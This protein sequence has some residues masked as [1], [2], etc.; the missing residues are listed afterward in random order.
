G[1]LLFARQV[2]D[3]G[4]HHLIFPD[5]SEGPFYIYSE[6]AFCKLFPTLSN[7]FVLR[8]ASASWDF[9]T[10]LIFYFLGKELGGKR[11]G[12]LMAALGAVSRIMMFKCYL[13]VDSPNLTTFSALA[14]LTQV[15][16]FKQPGHFRFVQWALGIV[17]G[18]YAYPAYRPWLL[19]LL[20][21]TIGWVM[22][23]SYQSKS[24]RVVWILGSWWI[25]AG[26]LS[27]CWAHYIWM[28]PL[29][30]INQAKIVLGF[31]TIAALFFTFFYTR[32][33]QEEYRLLQGL[34]FGIL[35]ISLFFFP[36]AHNELFATR[37]DEM[38]VFHSV[39]TMGGF[40]S[41]FKTIVLQ[42]LRMWFVKGMDRPT[43][44]PV[45]E[46]FFSFLDGSV[47]LLGLVYFLAR[48]NWKKGFLA[49]CLV[50]ALFP[51]VAI[52]GPHTS[53]MLSCVVPL[54]AL[55]ALGL[56]HLWELSGLETNRKLARLIFISALGL[57][58]IWA[59][60]A[61]LRSV[62]HWMD[63]AGTEVIVADQ[64]I[65]DCSKART[66]LAV[67]NYDTKS[68]DALLEG[69]TIYVMNSSNPIYLEKGSVK[70]DLVVLVTTQ[71]AQSIRLLKSQFP[72]AG[73]TLLAKKPKDSPAPFLFRVFIPSGQVSSDPKKLFYF[74]DCGANDWTRR[75]YDAQFGKHLGLIFAEDKV[76]NLQAP[77]P[78]FRPPISSGMAF[79]S[80]LL[81]RGRYL[82]SSKAFNDMDVTLNGK[83]IIDCEIGTRARQVLK[84][85]NLEGGKYNAKYFSY[86]GNA[87][88]F[89]TI[90]VEEKGGVSSTW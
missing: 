62:W 25:L 56:N 89:P 26:T 61:N 31:L 34:T 81:S 29:G 63:D 21:M 40:F 15:R 51:W 17:A 46:T 47:V 57:F 68:E 41:Y 83:E 64:A 78:L 11:V 76:E 16:L 32:H 28:P 33:R 19:F 8:F 86:F 48:P 82:F 5:G 59:S 36:L 52:A 77:F 72:K 35:I 80:V 79:K 67:Y 70:P 27:Y 24:R 84:K 3:Y 53:R 65:Q 74:R 30:H 45:D 50:P 58:W 42:I 60:E 87:S 20:V 9:L 22:V 23:L 12:L 13:G 71:D 43:S 39:K 54:Y 4:N 6:A 44:G 55:G 90:T 2:A 85:V 66:Y 49:L 88:A 75:F 73:W 37:M 7:L 10:V 1:V 18:M 14:V 69:R 38:D